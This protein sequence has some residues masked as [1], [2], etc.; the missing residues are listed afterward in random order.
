MNPSYISL[1]FLIVMIPLIITGQL[2]P[3]INL[4]IASDREALIRQ[5]AELELNKSLHNAKSLSQAQDDLLKLK[6]PGLTV[7]S[8]LV[9]TDGE[10]VLAQ[11]AYQ[12]SGLLMTKFLDL[13][14]SKTVKVI[15]VR[16]D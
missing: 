14:R 6:L 3:S 16:V 11:L 4:H 9:S 13:N 8:A 10:Y 1:A 12:Y 5:Q 7:K 2:M 15:A